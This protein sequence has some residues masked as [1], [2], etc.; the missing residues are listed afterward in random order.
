MSGKNQ[1]VSTLNWQSTNPVTAFLPN[2]LPGGSAPS[3][4]VSGT[5]S[6][7]NTIYSN[8]IDVA[9]MDNIG[10]E[11]TYTGTPTGV[12]SLLGSNSG[13]AFYPLTF[14]PALAQPA[15]AAGG[16]LIDLSGYPFKYFMLSY[17]NASGSGTLKAYLQLKDL[18]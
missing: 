9:K 10:V 1:F 17:V 8:I 16:Y 15:G 12:I 5:M 2:P 18:N 14:N 4:V 3:G 13:S 7:T 11:V 6:S